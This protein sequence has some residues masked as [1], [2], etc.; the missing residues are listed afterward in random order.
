MVTLPKPAKVSMAN[1][2]AWAVAMRLAEEG[3]E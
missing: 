2:V 3:E 1:R